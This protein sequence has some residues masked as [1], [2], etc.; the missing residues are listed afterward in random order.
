MELASVAG[1]HPKERPDYAF[2]R[3]AGDW[4]NVE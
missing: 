2:V 4:T 3:K 1:V